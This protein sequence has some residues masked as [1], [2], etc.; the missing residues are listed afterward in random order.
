MQVSNST[1]WRK[2]DAKEEAAKKKEH[3]KG[4]KAGKKGGGQPYKAKRRT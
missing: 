2:Q 4:K 3:S 1:L